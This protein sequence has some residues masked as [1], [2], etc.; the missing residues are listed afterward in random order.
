MNIDGP[1]LIED[2]P[3]FEDEGKEVEQ[4]PDETPIQDRRLITQPYDLVIE[5]LLEQI[6]R[7]TLHLRPI[8]DRPGFQ[9]RYVWPDK[10]A[11]RLIES[12]LLN[13]PIPPA[14][15]RKTTTMSLMLSMGNSA[16]I[17]YIAMP[18]INSS[19]QT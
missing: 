15:S 4:D 19:F 5:A 17:P 1:K 8:S 10:L 3:I 9:R 11:S 12:M 2:K 6:D 7:S 13:V 18:R 16:Y 14:T